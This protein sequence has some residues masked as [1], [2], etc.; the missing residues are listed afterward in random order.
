[1]LKNLCKKK[2]YKNTT[3]DP[4]I[5]ENFNGVLPGAVHLRIVGGEHKGV[6]YFEEEPDSL[7][8]IDTNENQVKH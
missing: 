4:V 3:G 7:V 8:E 1:M 2:R 5:V 6:T